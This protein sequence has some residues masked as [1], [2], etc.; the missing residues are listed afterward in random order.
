MITGEI[1]FNSQFLSELAG[2]WDNGLMFLIAI[3]FM[4]LAIQKGY[5][6]LLLITI[7]VGI[8]LANIP[9]SGLTE[10]DGLLVMLRDAGYHVEQVRTEVLPPVP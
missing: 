2:F 3:G 8:M 6:P 4:Y 9:F 1:P 5:E 7:G 10:E